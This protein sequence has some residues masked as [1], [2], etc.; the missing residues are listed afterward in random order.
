MTPCEKL[1]YKVVVVKSD[2]VGDGFQPGDVLT[3]SYVTED[4][5]AAYCR[6]NHGYVL[7]FGIEGESAR[8]ATVR[9]Y[10]ESEAEKRGVKFGVSGVNKVT[11]HKVTFVTENG[12]VNSLGEDLWEFLDNE[13]SKTVRIHPENIRLDH[14]P[15]FVAWEDA[16]E[17]LKYDASRVYYRGEP[18]KW[19]AKPEGALAEVVYVMSDGNIQLLTGCLTVKL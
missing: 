7:S 4:F 1:G 18:V 19:I 11:G 2:Y 13:T 5:N 16:P 17:H 9:P 8:G 15:E 6:N 10:T 12:G 3:V 14:E